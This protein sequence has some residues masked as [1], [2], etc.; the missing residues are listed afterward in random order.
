MGG[1][2]PLPQAAGL[3]EGKPDDAAGRQP[4]AASCARDEAPPRAAKE[5]GE[6]SQ[7]RMRDKMLKLQRQAQEVVRWEAQQISLLGLRPTLWMEVF[8]KKHRPGAVLYGYWQRWELSNTEM[9]FFDWL[10]CGPGSLVDLP[11]YPRR[12][13]DEWHVLY[14]TNEQQQ[15]FEVE[16]DPATGLFAWGLDGSL[17]TL[18]AE[19]SPEEEEAEEPPHR[20]EREIAVDELIQ[21]RLQKSAHR[22][23]LLERLRADAERAEKLREEPTRERIALMTQELM[24]EGLLRQLRDPFFHD[25]LDADDQPCTPASAK[26]FPAEPRLRARSTIDICL[27]GES[28]G[29]LPNLSWG[30]VLDATDHEEGLK[31]VG[32][33]RLA[34]EGRVAKGIFVLDKFGKLYC[35]PKLRGTFQHSS[36][37][38][39]HCVKVAGGIRISGG[40]VSELSPHSGHYQPL[41]EQISRMREDWA[42]KGVDFTSVVVKP[43]EK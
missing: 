27:L 16:I 33:G 39:G 24:D 36:F 3:R 17:V 25:R 21:P 29:L 28:Q 20:T 41:P 26:R 38:R 19:V 13:L 23:R 22:N 7:E 42:R 40:R 10:D 31:M 34:D 4:L 2:S 14:L 12:L 32:G 43:Y 5:A 15:L 30:H 35:G 8:D 9:G 11:T 1:R 37:V 6:K 18:P